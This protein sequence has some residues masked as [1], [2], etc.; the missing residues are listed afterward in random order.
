MNTLYSSAYSSMLLAAAAV[1][2]L[3]GVSG[4]QE[5]QPVSP[6]VSIVRVAAVGGSYLGV[7]LRE[8]DSDRAR[9]LKLREEAGVEITR[10]EDDSPAS[11]AGLKAGDVVLSYNGTR[12]EGMEQFSRFVRETPPGRDVKLLISRD[13]NTLTITARVGA[14]KTPFPI[15]GMQI[16]RVE[17]P[18]MPALPDLPRGIMMWRTAAL[19]IEAE[20]LRG[21]LADFFGVKEGVLV[22]SVMRD[23]PASRAGLKAGDV[24]VKVGDARVASP[25]DVT[26]A[27]HSAKDKKALAIVILRD[28]KE[29]TVT[30]SIDDDRSDWGTP[31]PRRVSG[32]AIRM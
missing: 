3:P 4:A 26:S 21:Q 22:R 20:P 25:G 7:N 24:I 12:V 18:D 19:G 15:A 1:G 14:R 11:K 17:M 16:P 2:L 10:V 29:M 8:I 23:T 6:D 32:R 5:L 13:G 27:I 9:E 30:A 31:M 28:H